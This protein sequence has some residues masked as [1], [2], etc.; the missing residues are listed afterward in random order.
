MGLSCEIVAS[1]AIGMAGMAATGSASKA[2]I[3]S[4]ANLFMLDS[5]ERAAPRPE[6]A[7]L[8]IL[9]LT[10]APAKDALV[11]SRSWPMVTTSQT[12]RNRREKMIERCDR[13]QDRL[14]QSLERVPEGDQS[15]CD[16]VTIVTG[17]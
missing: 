17:G 11:V 13:G 14:S 4:K 10:I 3:T 7:S 15:S 16:H 8:N 5:E 12:A 1:G 2:S 6:T 9:G